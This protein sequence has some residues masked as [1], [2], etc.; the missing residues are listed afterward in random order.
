MLANK[1]I[2]NVLILL[3]LLL[4]AIIRL[5][6]ISQL[7]DRVWWVDEIDYMALGQ[8]IATGHGY[9]NPE[10]DATAFRPPGYPLV[11]A[12][13]YK[14]GVDQVPEIRFVHVIVSVLTIFLLSLLSL[15]IG[16]PVAAVVSTLVAAG[17]PYFVFSTGTLFAF[18]WFSLTLVA[19]VYFLICGLHSSHW[20]LFIIAGLFMGLA[21]LTRTSAAV[22]AVVIIPWLLFVMRQSLKRFFKMSLIFVLTMSAVVLPWIVRNYLV[23]DEPVISTNGARNLW[24]GNNPESTQHSGSNIE[25]P[26]EL[27]RRLDGK[28]EIESD[29][30][31][32][33]EAMKNIKNNPQHYATLAVHKGLALWRLDPSPTTDGYPRYKSLYSLVS[34]F[35]YAPILFLAV[36]GF[37]FATQY[38][39]KIMLLWILFGLAFTLLHAVYISKVR[40]RLPL[41][42]FLIIM[43]GSAVAS[44]IERFGTIRQTFVQLIL[45]PSAK[46]SPQLII[47]RNATIQ[48]QRHKITKGHK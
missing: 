10:G 5:V 12:A 44:I 7:D 16:G 32:S 46:S 30:I 43:A 40:F 33:Q 48:P 28:T 29:K 9:V 47:K 1:K 21:I 18:T 13:L 34:I 39:K 24:L 17:Y 15:K 4:A 22:L 25:L 42:F 23:F 36:A 11:L 8:S 31:Y 6:Y 37:F 41:D 19:A 45:T 3:A 2:V 14:I 27:E 35:S 38:Q 26:E 20:W